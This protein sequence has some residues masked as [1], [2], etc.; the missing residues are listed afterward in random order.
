[1]VKTYSHPFDEGVGGRM[2][3]TIKLCEAKWRLNCYQAP[4]DFRTATLS[5][6]R[7]L[8][9]P[10]GAERPTIIEQLERD[11]IN[12]CF[13]SLDFRLLRETAYVI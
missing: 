11:E 10:G 3:R 2:R 4:E 12:T 8:G 9:I 5:L 7:D 6:L 13:S 1:M